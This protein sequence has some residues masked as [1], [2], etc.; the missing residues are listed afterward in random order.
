MS[1]L[2]EADAANAKLTDI[3]VRTAADLAAVVRSGGKFCSSLL[4]YLH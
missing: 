2:S 1:E 4:L 3:G